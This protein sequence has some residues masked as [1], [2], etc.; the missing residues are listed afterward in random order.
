MSKQVSYVQ[1]RMSQERKKRW[2]IYCYEND[3]TMT[4]LVKTSVENY[5]ADK[6]AN[7]VKSDE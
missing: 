7:Q 6:Q 3:I 2:K 4:T 1:L 5:L